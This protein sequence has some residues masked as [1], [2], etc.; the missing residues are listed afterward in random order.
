M[1]PRLGLRFLAS[2]DSPPT[3]AQAGDEDEEG[4]PL[5]GLNGEAA[6]AAGGGSEDGEEDGVLQRRRAPTG[7]A[8]ASL[9]SRMLFLWVGPLLALG[10]T[11]QLDMADLFELPPESDVEH[12]A[13]TFGE[14]LAAENARAEREAAEWGDLPGK[15]SLRERLGLPATFHALNAT[16]GGAFIRAGFFKL[17]SDTLQFFPAVM[18]ADYLQAL[19]GRRSHILA[20]MGSTNDAGCAAAYALA[21]FFLPLAR[22]L[23]EQ[24]YFYRVQKINMGVK[25]ALTTA[26]YRKS[27]RVSSASG[28]TTSTGEVLNLMQM[29]A[30]RCAE[31][32][33]YLHVCWSAALQTTGYITLLSMYIGWS[34]IG[35]LGAMFALVPIQSR[36]F[37]IIAVRRKAQMALSDRRVRM[38]NELVGAGM[39]ICKLNAWEAPMLAAIN[40]VR[41]EELS[42]ARNLAYINAFVSCLITTLPTLVA[43]SAFTL[44]S[45]VM[46]RPM[47]PWVVFPALSLFNQVRAGLGPATALHVR[48]RTARHPPPC[49]RPLV[50]PHAL[51]RPHSCA[52]PSCSCRACCPCAPTASCRSSGCSATP[53]CRTRRRRRTA[54]QQGPGRAQARGQQI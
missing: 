34:V 31:T 24:A 14:H 7:V 43:V 11:R 10:R 44:Y 40:A 46:H 1:G 20:R 18:L 39:R 4:A 51:A 25:A 12:L 54:P 45:G 2:S 3:R 36:V 17:G 26:V 35:G 42:V 29:D 32:V 47:V 28:G 38:E 5:V 33:T 22:T 52:S 21:L 49:R 13:R 9:L 15:R 48:R 8:S 23:V 37:R 53:R 6:E 50:V 27:V 16:F 30:S 19:S 41:D